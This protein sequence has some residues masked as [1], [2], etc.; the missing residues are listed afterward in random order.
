MNRSRIN[1]SFHEECSQLLDQRKQAKMQWL[2]DLDQ[3][4]VGNL[5]NVRRAAGR[6]FRNK[7]AEYLKAKIKTLETI[8]KNKNIRGL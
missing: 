1:P 5:K 7:K 4:N 2:Q 3:S 8:S 6:Y